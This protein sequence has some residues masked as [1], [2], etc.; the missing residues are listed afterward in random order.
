M[1]ALARSS[2]YIKP[3]S[4]EESTCFPDVIGPEGQMGGILDPADE[5][6]IQ[7][8]VAQGCPQP[9]QGRR[10]GVSLHRALRSPEPL[11][12]APF[13]VRRLTIGHGSVH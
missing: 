9:G 12:A 2:E 13:V 3:G 7:Q 1:A 5:A 8:W 11:P 10:S 6:V 4:V